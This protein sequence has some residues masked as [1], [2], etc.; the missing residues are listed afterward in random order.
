MK[1]I[2]SCENC[3]REI[4][5]PIDKGT[6]FVTCPYCNNSFKVNPDDP[7]L[8]SKG[9]FDLVKSNQSHPEEFFFGRNFDS[10]FKTTEKSK[11]II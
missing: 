11:S 5:F 7:I 10:A 8:Y 2:R 1:Y 4:R 9:R 3:Y 6:L